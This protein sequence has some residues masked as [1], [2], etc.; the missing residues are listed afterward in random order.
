MD[1]LGDPAQT[2]GP[3]PGRRRSRRCWPAAPARCRC[4]TSPS[5]GGCAARGVCSARRSAGR[6]SV[7][8]LTPTRRPGRARADGF[9][10]GD[11]RGVRTAET[12]RHAESLRRADGDVGAELSGRDGEHAGQQIGGDRR[13]ARR[14]R[15][16]RRWPSRQS[17]IA[18]LEV[19][20][21]NSAPKQPPATSLDVADDELDAD[22]LGPGR[23]ARRSSAD[24]CRG[25][26]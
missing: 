8:V 1:P 24:A 12:H 23:A 5:R 15:A 21:L 9:L 16:P 2:F 11:E 26:R 22:R 6:P 19:G 18:P 13:Q 4:S 7:S 25:A 10:G 3:V 14:R 17:V 20:R